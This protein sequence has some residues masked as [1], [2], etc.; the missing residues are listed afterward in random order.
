MATIG[1]AEA[2][3]LLM[4]IVMLAALT[5]I[6]GFFPGPFVAFAER[7]AEQLLDPTAY[8]TAVLRAGS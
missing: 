8:V 4:P 3:S 7:T 5:V 1:R 2:I 6:I